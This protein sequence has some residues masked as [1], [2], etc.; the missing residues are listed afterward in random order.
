[1]HI[2]TDRA[3]TVDHVDWPDATR[4]P[5]HHQAIIIRAT[6]PGQRLT[7]R[8]QIDVDLSIVE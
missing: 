5:F 3:I 2:S 4:A 1:M 7:M 6:T 8:T